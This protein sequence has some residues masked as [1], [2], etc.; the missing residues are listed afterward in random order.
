VSGRALVV[1]ILAGGEGS[2]VGGADKGF[3]LRDGRPQIEGVLDAIHSA[4]NRAG[5]SG[6]PRLRV[7]ANRNQDRYS[8]L[9]PEVLGDP[10]PEGPRQGPMIGL[11]RM[12]EGLDDEDVL[13][14]P[15][16]V[17]PNNVLA[18]A[19]DLLLR[20]APGQ[21]AMIVD[22]A[23]DQPLFCRIPATFSVGL[24]EAIQS[25]ERSPRAW[26]GAQDVHRLRIVGR[27]HNAN[28]P[29]DFDPDA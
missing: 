24:R 25:G 29:S 13:V 22:D 21:L 3:L 15:I 27:L 14:L 26:L 18:V 11:A 1:G 28:L 10:F 7:S 12:L 2:R 9:I 16:D 20:V 8:K 4:W 17:V 23:G 6:R 5:Y 19:L